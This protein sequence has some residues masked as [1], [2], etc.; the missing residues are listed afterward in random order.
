MDW[1]RKREREKRSKWK[2]EGKCEIFRERSSTF[3]LKFSAIGPLA[4]GEARS[5]VASH[6]KDY[7]WVPVSG[8]FDKL[9]KK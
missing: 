2:R 5:K 7:A 3:S 1:E 8:S 6:G 9:L 4:S